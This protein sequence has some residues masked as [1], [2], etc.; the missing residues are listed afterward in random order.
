MSFL[1]YAIIMFKTQD[2]WERKKGAVD[3]WHLAQG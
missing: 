3:I 2:K 1:F